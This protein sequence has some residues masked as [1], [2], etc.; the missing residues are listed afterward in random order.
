MRC[1]TVITHYSNS[2]VAVHPRQS[3]CRP[4]MYCPPRAAQPSPASISAECHCGCRDV[5]L[6]CATVSSIPRSRRWTSGRATARRHAVTTPLAARTHTPCLA[7]RPIR[8]PKHSQHPYSL[9]K[10]AQCM[11]PPTHPP[12]HPP[13]AYTYAKKLQRTRQAGVATPRT[14]PPHQPHTH[15]E[16]EMATASTASSDNDAAVCT[17]HQTLP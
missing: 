17:P 16:M 12:S 3:R 8:A 1:Y 2:G 15:N 13:R 11:H 9:L 10:P 4:P 14:R 5:P 6:R 7:A